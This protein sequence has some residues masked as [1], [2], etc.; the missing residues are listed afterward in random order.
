[1][2]RSDEK[3][4][5]P[6]CSRCTSI[7]G[8]LHELYKITMQMVKVLKNTEETSRDKTI[9]TMNQLIEERDQVIANI[10]APYSEEE[11]KIGQQVVKLNEQIKVNMD[12]LYEN[13]KSDMKKIKQQK[14]L[15]RTYINP[16]G[17]IK[18]TDGMYVDNKQ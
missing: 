11:M 1:M 16:Y 7:M 14:K 18:T 5:S 10:K 17:P 12:K 6:I 3:R 9:D 8:R 4:V 13:V 15:N 2:E